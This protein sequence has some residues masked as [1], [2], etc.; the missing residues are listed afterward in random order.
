MSGPPRAPLCGRRVVAA[1]LVAGAGGLAVAWVLLRTLVAATPSR[2]SPASLFW[3]TV[4][5]GVS[6][7]IAGMAVEAVR[8][9]R[10]HSPEPGYWRGRR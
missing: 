1:G 10:Q 2:L 4:L 7:L 8:Q 5:L 9:L 6:G 3:S